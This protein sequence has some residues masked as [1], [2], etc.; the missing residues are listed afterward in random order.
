MHD[1]RIF[2]EL[3]GEDLRRRLFLTS[4]RGRART[5]APAGLHHSGLPRPPRHGPGETDA[6]L[7]LS[8]AG[9]SAAPRRERRV[10]AGRRRIP[11]PDRP[12]RRRCRHADAGAR[13]PPNSSACKRPTVRIGDSALF[14]ARSR[15]SRPRPPWQRRLARTFGDTKRLQGLDRQ[16]ERQRVGR[17]PAI[18]RK[19]AE[20]RAARS[21][22]VGIR[23]RRH[24]RPDARTRSP[25]GSSE[26]AALADGIGERAAA[27]LEHFPRRCRRSPETGADGRFAALAQARR[28]STS[29]AR[30]T[31]SQSASTAFAGHGIDSETLTFAADFGRRLDYYTG[32]V[33]EIHDKRRAAGRS[34]AAAVTTGS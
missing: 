19:T 16:G 14:S 17:L 9:V 7:R 8:R 33:F 31:A 10:P 34:S 26:K 18:D 23:A 1:A 29:A 12:R 28:A 11:R 27:A 5:G 15:R 13:P 30:S 22:S 3:A 25:T 32:F 6:R 2:V 24:R 4:A 20:G 21:P